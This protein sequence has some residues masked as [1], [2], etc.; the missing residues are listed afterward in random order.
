MLC[1][2]QNVSH[3]EI[4]MEDFADESEE[5]DHHSSIAADHPKLTSDVRQLSSRGGEVHEPEVFMC[6]ITQVRKFP[7]RNIKYVDQT[8]PAKLHLR[9]L[10]LLRSWTTLLFATT[11][12]QVSLER[13][14]WQ[15]PYCDWHDENVLVLIDTLQLEVEGCLVFHYDLVHLFFLTFTN[16]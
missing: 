12:Q 8:L 10:R 6:P 13:T 3:P 9:N 15:M 1:L 11:E 14:I 4:Q 16:V 7:A 2:V 5:Q